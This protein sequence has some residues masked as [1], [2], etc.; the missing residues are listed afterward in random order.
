MIRKIS[1]LLLIGVF[2][3]TACSTPSDKSVTPGPGGSPNESTN[4]D[5]QVEADSEPL[6]PLLQNLVIERHGTQIAVAEGIG[7]QLAGSVII[8]IPLEGLAANAAPHIAKIRLGEHALQEGKIPFSSTGEGQGSFQY[9]GGSC[10]GGG[11]FGL[12]YEVYGELDPDT[13]AITLNL[14]EKWTGGT[15]SATCVGVGG[16]SA[17]IPPGEITLEPVKMGICKVEDSQKEHSWVQ[18]P[19]ASG[20]IKWED[21]FKLEDQ[22]EREADQVA[23]QVMREPVK[24]M[25]D[26]E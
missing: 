20:G 1:V 12:V 6:P 10:T 15:A 25:C 3:L 18:H 2:I 17:A 26:P 21:T 7:W 11:Q 9:L 16:G 4:Q 23:D 5:D 8:E 13:G 24:S 22:Y 19:E 14:I